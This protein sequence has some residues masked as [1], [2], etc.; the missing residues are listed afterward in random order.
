MRRQSFNRSLLFEP[1]GVAKADGTPYQVFT[2]FFRKGCLK[3]SRQR[4]LEAFESLGKQ[5]EN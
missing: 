2:P 5:A 4:A 3:A 1:R